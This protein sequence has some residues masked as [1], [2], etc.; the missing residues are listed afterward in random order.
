VNE[1]VNRDK[2]GED[3]GMNMEVGLVVLLYTLHNS[4]VLLLTN[5]DVHKCI[6]T[7]KHYYNITLVRTSMHVQNFTRIN[8]TNCQLTYRY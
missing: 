5:D 6:K 7:M 2:T 4:A 1:E 8:L 3:D